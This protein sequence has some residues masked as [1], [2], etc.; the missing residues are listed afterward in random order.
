MRARD[1]RRLWAKAGGKRARQIKNEAKKQSIK[2]PE[3]DS[4]MPT[5]AAAE[6]DFEQILLCPHGES[7]AFYYKRRLGVYNFS[8][9][10]YKDCNAYCFM[11]PEHE[12]N[13]G[14]VEVG[15]CLYKYLQKKSEYEN[16][17][18][19][20][21]SEYEN[22]IQEIDLFSDNTSA[23]NRNRYVAYSLWYARQQFGFKRITHTFL[24]KGHTETENDSVHS[25]IERK[26]KNIKLYTPDQWYGAVR[27]AR[28]TKQPFEVIEMNHGDFID[29]KA[30]S[31][32][33]VK[34]FFYDDDKIQ[35]YWT[36]VRQVTSTA[37]RPDVLQ[38]KT[39]FDGQPQ[40]LTVY[41]RNRRT[42]PVSTPLTMPLLG[43]PRPGISK[44]KKKDLIQLCKDKQ[45]PGV[46]QSFYESLP[47]NN[48]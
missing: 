16:H 4:P 19:E 47:V 15:T 8:I 38:I 3:E 30:M 43:I 9:Y 1:G 31:E 21:K 34:H 7:S 42:I 35:I 33:V 48:E 44:D 25:T 22:H 14:S 26:T 12:G 23:Q 29:F 28:V 41:R 13:R 20:K 32:E 37:E 39:N 11:W 17:I 45:I 36:H 2:G 27:S 10:D 5:T 46:Y 24:E 6:F 40:I 18:Q